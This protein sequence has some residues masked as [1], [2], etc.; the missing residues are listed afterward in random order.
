MLMAVVGALLALLGSNAIAP[1]RAAHRSAAKVCTNKIKRHGKVIRKR[2]ACPDF[3]LKTTRT[4][5]TVQ[6]GGAA[7]TRIIKVVPK[8]GFKKS[9][10]ISVS[11]LSGVTSALAASGGRSTTLTVTAALTASPRSTSIT[12]TGRGGGKT[13]TLTLPVT[14]TAPPLGS[15]RSYPYPL[16]TTGAVPDW[17]VRIN[18][19][20]FSAWSLIAAANMFNDPPPAGWTDVLISMTMTYTGTGSSTTFLNADLALIGASNIGY[21]WYEHDC[22]VLPET[23]LTGDLDTIFTG[24]SATGY[25]CV[26]VPQS[27]VSTLVGFWEP[28]TGPLS[29]FALR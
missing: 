23:D 11:T 2:V 6:A 28:D 21:K 15:T 26:Q 5:L 9:V 12:V 29:W 8:H 22:G 3:A 4:P 13:H 16:G 1:A 25:T 18:S 20:N 7:G 10:S 27:Q 17:K 24:G 14:I 19:V